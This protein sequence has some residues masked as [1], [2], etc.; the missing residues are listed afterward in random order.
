MSEPAD[1]PGASFPMPRTCPF[2]MPPEYQKMRGEGGV[3]RVRMPDGSAVW[4]VSRYDLA[5]ELLMNEHLSVFRGHAA[6]PDV[7]GRGGARG[8]IQP[9]GMLTW[10]DPPEHSVYRRMLMNEFT[11]RRM[12]HL[13]EPIERFI[14]TRIDEVLA[15]PRPVDLVTALALPVTRKVICELLGIP[16]EQ[17][18]AFNVHLDR[19]LGAGTS[20]EDRAASWGA[21]RSL[22]GDLIAEREARPAD[23][24][25]S[26][27]VV[28]YKE[29]VGA[30]VDYE[31][32]IGLI[33]ALRTAGHESTAAMISTGLAVLLDNPVQ[34]DQIKADRTLIPGAVEELLRFLSVADRATARVT[35]ADIE[36][37]GT[38]IPAGEGV[39]VL[40]ASA[41][42]DEAV[43]DDPASFRLRQDSAR[44]LAFGYGIHQCIG[45][46]LAR[47]EIEAVIE[48]LVARVP[49]LRLA[50]GVNE[51]TFA[52][53]SLFYSVAELPVTW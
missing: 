29:A 52:Q 4:A 26:R 18:D 10:M 27:L 11:F 37:G 35:T 42:H 38:T 15:G 20:N 25:I 53:D 2:G 5:R 41:N 14:D 44:H 32:L 1:E 36:L 33:M 3:T 13:R 8:S 7:T 17:N 50:V 45:Q 28:K 6:F 43:F 21:V 19:V 22:V 24:L 31:V 48:R 49:G 34:F 40:N 16:E 23:D 12:G 47:L 46:N 39:L 51:L 9:K 30:E